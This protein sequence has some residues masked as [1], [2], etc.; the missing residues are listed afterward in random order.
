MG[1]DI[2]IISCEHGGN[3]VPP[4]YAGLFAGHEPLLAT[5]R[6]WDPGALEL[7]KELAAALQAPFF[8]ATTTRLLIDLNRSIGHGQ[9]HSEL[10]RQLPAKA[11]REIVAQHYTPYRQVLEAEVERLI[12]GGQRV[13]HIA[14]HS[15][16]PELRG[17]MRQADLALLYDPARA[18]ERTFAAQWLTSLRSALPHLRLR[19]N[20]PYEGKGDG[21]MSLLRK[22]YADEAYVGIELEVNQRFVMDGG[23]AWDALRRGVVESLA[24]T[25]PHRRQ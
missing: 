1:R 2:V 18:G 15:F 19:R 6:G 13:I 21:V 14:S 25:S 16:T 3:E 7:G 22:R 9:L 17:V 10:T 5:H 23:A 8:S 24:P 11:R 12:A 4:A 20:Y